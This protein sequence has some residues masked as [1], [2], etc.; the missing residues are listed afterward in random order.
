MDP[1][2]VSLCGTKLDLFSGKQMVIAIVG[3]PYPFVGSS[4]P[5]R[6]LEIR[7]SNV[8]NEMKAFVVLY[9]LTVVPVMVLLVD[10]H[11]GALHAAVEGR[12]THLPIFGK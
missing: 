2:H 11:I 4:I 6:E 8:Q 9:H 1:F 3:H 12:A 10:L 7:I 5:E